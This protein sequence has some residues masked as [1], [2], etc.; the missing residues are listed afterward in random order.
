MTDE[1]AAAAE[2]TL[3]GDFLQRHP[4]EAANT[5]ESMP[6]ERAATLLGEFD[7]ATLAPVI[8]R[9]SP[10]QSE[11]ILRLL[12][13]KLATG[14]LNRLQIPRAATILRIMDVETRT[15]ILQRLDRNAQDDI[16]LLLDSPADSAAAMMD[17]RV[18]FLRPD[19]AVNDALLLLR[20]QRYQRSHSQSRRIMLLV[21]H[22]SRIEGI[23]AIQDLA[24]ADPADRLRDYMQ[25]VPAVVG[26]AAD[27]EEI[28]E[29]MED[30]R[31]SSLPVVDND[32]RLIGIVRY[33]ELVAVAKED[34]VGDIQAMFGV[35]RSE[36][37]LSPPM[38]SVSRRLPWLQINLVTAFLAAAVVGLF[39]D[40]I[41]RYTALAILLP[42][43]AGQSG[44]TGAQALAVVMRGLALR[45]IS[46]WHWPRVLRKE[47]IVS[48][49]N[50]LGVA[51]TTCAAVFLWSR[52]TGLM[53]IIGLAMVSSMVI[54]GLA[55]AAV[56]L[57]LTRF[58]Q[59]PAQAS[60]IILTTVTDIAGFF[61]FLGIAT[62]LIN[63][64]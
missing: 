52:S 62:L 17:P 41:A 9:V 1:M 31:V 23:V 58:G 35:S 46:I 49:V 63:L 22:E 8:E 29:A 57:L 30:H 28:V 37:A 33:D 5:L 40:T 55:G 34:A 44:N 11:G 43:V 3:H 45:E 26:L 60:S 47:L 19:M 25:P 20:G 54:A 6:P 24:L 39:E 61:S 48:L 64:L 13:A 21:D 51:L 14:I 36:Q 16:N 56:P 32:G 15:D 4:V 12:D 50:G 38:F 7:A 2:Q 59:D 10:V 53:T 18:L 27:K 42:V